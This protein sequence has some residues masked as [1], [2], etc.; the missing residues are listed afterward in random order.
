MTKGGLIEEK[1]LASLK[2]SLRAAVHSYRRRPLVLLWREEASSKI[3]GGA[4]TII[5]S[6]SS[7]LFVFRLFSYLCDATRH[8]I[9][10]KKKKRNF[11]TKNFD[12]NFRYKIVTE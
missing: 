9:T 10:K 5:V 2:Q 6:S 12:R 8:N 11:V 3:F 1:H 7:S 4:A